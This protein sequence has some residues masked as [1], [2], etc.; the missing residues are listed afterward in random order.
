MGVLRKRKFMKI[1]E[2]SQKSMKEMLK[3]LYTKE[4]SVILW[5]IMNSYNR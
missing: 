4:Q 1:Y 2:N 5:E 3:I